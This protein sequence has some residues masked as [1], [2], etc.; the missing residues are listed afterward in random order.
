MLLTDKVYPVLAG[1]CSGLEGYKMTPDV[2]ARYA[3]LCE[4][5]PENRFDT[6]LREKV[7]P[8][9]AWVLVMPRSSHTQ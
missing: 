3:Q 5:R 9:L 6:V 7:Y 1:M 4:G 2:A 8:I